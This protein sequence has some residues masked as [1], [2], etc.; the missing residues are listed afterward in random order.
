MVQINTIPPAVPAG[1]PVPPLG[2]GGGD[3]QLTTTISSAYLNVKPN[4]WIMLSQPPYQAPS[5]GTLP[6]W[7]RWYRVLAADQTQGTGS[8][9]FTRNVTLAGPDW[10]PA[11][12]GSSVTVATFATIVDGVIGVYERAIELEET[13]NPWSPN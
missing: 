9:P 1:S 11:S 2:F 6:A 12:G 7:Y 3:V 8:G 4:Q 5:G 13:G 10:N